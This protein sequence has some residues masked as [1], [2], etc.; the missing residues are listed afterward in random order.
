MKKIYTISRSEDN[1]IEP[2]IFCIQDKITQGLTE[3]IENKWEP[4]NLK[5]IDNITDPKF[6]FIFIYGY[7]PVCNENAYLILSQMPGLNNVYFLPIIID[8]EKYYIISVLQIE[9]S[10]LN[11]KKSK[12]E[13]FTDKSIMRVDSYV[14]NE[15]TPNSIMFKISESSSTFFVTEDFVN[16]IAL[17]SLSGINF[18]GCKVLK[19]SIWNKIF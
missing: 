9:K 17:H 1:I 18:K 8:N 6:D 3:H 11:R 12:I 2:D 4:V 10:I 13:Y 14:F 16:C 19:K 15:F 5:W 7:I